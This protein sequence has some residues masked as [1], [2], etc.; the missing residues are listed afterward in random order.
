M[1]EYLPNETIL[2]IFSFLELTELYRAFSS[3]NY[4]FE[5]L[6]YNNYTPLYARLISNTTLPLEKF[7]FRISKFSLIDWTPNNVLLLITNS[8]LPRL[9]YLNIESS[10]NDYFGQPTNDLIHQILSL[11]NLFKCQIE[12]SPTLYI[13]NNQLP[14]SHTIQHMNLSMITLDMLFNLLE[15][16]PK[17]CSLNVWLNSNGR[18]FDSHTYRE[19][20]CSNLKKLTIGLHNDITLQEIL[21]LLQHMPILKSFEMFGSVWDRGFL[22]EQQWKY[23]ILGENSFPLLN[24][25][26]INICIRYTAN[27]Q[28]AKLILS[29]FNQD[30]FHRTNFIITH[31]YMFWFYLTCFWNS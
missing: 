1:F 29:Q 19:Y 2:E 22:N 31:D 16:V 12:L 25:I 21:F 26:K 17:L 15:H 14:I 9:T 24:K 23:I 6:L 5:C 30:I 18:I 20:Y 8:N 27:T 7:L 13:L 28:N 11:S 4:R 3:L 10:N